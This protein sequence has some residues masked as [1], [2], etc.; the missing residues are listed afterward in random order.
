MEK[1]LTYLRAKLADIDGGLLQLDSLLQ[2][3][4]EIEAEEKTSEQL[5]SSMIQANTVKTCTCG[6]LIEKDNG[7]NYL[8]CSFCQKEWCWKC[9]REKY[10]ECNEKDHNSH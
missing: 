4:A 6:A 7:C 10:K 3:L 1:D 5:L 8:K 2:R 9:W